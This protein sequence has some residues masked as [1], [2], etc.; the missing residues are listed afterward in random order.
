MTI[1]VNDDLKGR[2]PLR[3]GSDSIIKHDDLKLN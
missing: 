3:R 2:S 1:S